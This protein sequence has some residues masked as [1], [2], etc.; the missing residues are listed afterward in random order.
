MTNS[1]ESVQLDR[2]EEYFVAELK[3]KS[4]Q[5]LRRFLAGSWTASILSP[6]AIEE[7]YQYQE[8]RQEEAQLEQ[9]VPVGR[10]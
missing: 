8:L 9:A 7:L 6:D 1:Q 2:T 4:T 10:D 3:K 5:E